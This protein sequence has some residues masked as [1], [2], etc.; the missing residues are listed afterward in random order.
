MSKMLKSKCPRCHK[1]IDFRSHGEGKTIGCPHCGHETILR[2]WSE[3]IAAQYDDSPGEVKRV[4]ELRGSGCFIV[5]LALP[6][7]FFGPWGI[8][9]GIALLFWSR[10]LFRKFVCSRCGNPMPDPTVKSCPTCK[11]TFEKPPQ[12][13]G[14]T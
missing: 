12:S 14:S 10:R 8:L 13:T 2:G 3:E 11:I 5:V 4:A 9:L 7:M 6:F 1:F